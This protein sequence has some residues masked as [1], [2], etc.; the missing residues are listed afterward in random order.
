MTRRLAL[1][2][3]LAGLGVVVIVRPTF[4][5]PG[6]ALSLAEVR[7]LARSTIDRDFPGL[8]LD[9]EMLVAIAWIESGFNPSAVRIEPYLADA[10]VGLMQTLVGTA[11][12]LASTDYRRFGTSVSFADLF[13][14]ERSM[15]Y[16]ASYVH[17]LTFM[18]P[19]RG[20]GRG[21]EEF[22]VRAYNAGPGNWR[23][24]AAE[25]YFARYRAAREMF[26]TA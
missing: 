13:R 5:V 24:G 19:E 18:A 3:A 4:S 20:E 23:S 15:Y 7:A 26:G 12:W 9:P 8:G 16:G 6:R 25:T 21:S 14:P 11:D 22:V 17:Y 1:A 2:L 10:S